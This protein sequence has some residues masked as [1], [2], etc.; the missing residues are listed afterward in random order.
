MFL[1]AEGWYTV[2]AL[3][4]LHLVVPVASVLGKTGRAVVGSSCLRRPVPPPVSP[5]EC[6]T[7]VIA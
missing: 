3:S 5:G 6:R 1:E 2:T 4:G 7:T